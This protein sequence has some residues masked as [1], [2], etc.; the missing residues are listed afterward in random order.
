[1]MVSIIRPNNHYAGFGPRT[2]NMFRKM[3][4]LSEVTWKDKKVTLTEEEI[5]LTS[6]DS[7]QTTFS[8]FL[9]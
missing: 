1:M 5:F 6:T 4:G 2:A 8:D 3:L 7:K 9:K